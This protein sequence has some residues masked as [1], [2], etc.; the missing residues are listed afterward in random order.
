MEYM[1]ASSPHAIKKQFS[2]P[3]RLRPG[4][5]SKSHAG[6]ELPLKRT[7]GTISGVGTSPDSG[8]VPESRTDSPKKGRHS[9]GCP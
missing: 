6:L 4:E 8:G 1:S 5:N 7:W 2:K 3:A 9:S